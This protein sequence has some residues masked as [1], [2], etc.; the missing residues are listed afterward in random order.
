MFELKKILAKESSALTEEEKAFLR[1]NEAKL[2]DEQKEK[3]A[4]ALETE[5]EGGV[6]EEGLKALVSKAA[7]ESAAKIVEKISDG[8]IAK[9]QTKL[10]AARAK[11][12]EEAD[13]GEGGGEKE[14]KKKGETTR[15]FLLALMDGDRARAKALTTS[16]SGS[17]PD[18]AKAG[19]LIPDELRAEVLRLKETQ[20]G[21][22]RRDMFYLPFSGPGNSRVIP[23]LGTS[24][25][26]KWTDEAGKK[27]ST[28]PKFSVVTQTLKKLAAIVPFTEEIL[29][30]SAIDLVALVGQLFAE[31]VAKEEDVQF[32]A[33]TGSP[34][35]GILNNGSVNS[36]TMLTGD[37]DDNLADELLRLQDATPSGAQDGAKYYLHR[38]WLNKVRK[39]KDTNGQ[40][41]FQAPAN[42]QPG[43]IWNKPY[44]TSD[45]FPAV[46]DT[47]VGD[48]FVLYANLKQAAVFGDKQQLRVKLL[49]EAT[50][51]DTDDSTSINLAEQDMVA[52]RVVERVGYVVA[53]AAAAT[54]LKYDEAS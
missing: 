29:E 12:I 51:T 52:L 32:F 50:I 26:V 23:A 1:E 22:A 48:P 54:V 11:A 6:D 20:Y 30:D 27:K 15:S 3:F 18:D 17:S 14:T 28:Q 4:E 41:I 5:D 43:T 16:E 33:G 37:A 49:E 38:T 42:G 19:L 53:L 24:V 44:E 47:E 39:L 25:S 9:F 34:W 46:A 8:L 13:G 40:Y 7:E 10:K 45:A 36:V 35:T 31:A 2:S 21:L